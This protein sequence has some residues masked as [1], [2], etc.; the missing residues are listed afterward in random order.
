M[1]L[2][3]LPAHPCFVLR[4]PFV[5]LSFIS[6]AEALMSPLCPK[7][8]HFGFALSCYISVF[9]ESLK[10]IYIEKNIIILIFPNKEHKH[11]TMCKRIYIKEHNHIN[12]S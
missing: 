9:I 1:A 10:H 8:D 12:I 3:V 11:K 2:P 7:M 5:S 6:R 4:V